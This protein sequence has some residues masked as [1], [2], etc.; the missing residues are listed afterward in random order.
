MMQASRLRCSE[1]C[2]KYIY[3]RKFLLQLAQ[4]IKNFFISNANCKIFF[5]YYN[6]II[7]IILLHIVLS[8]NIFSTARPAY[9]ADDSPKGNPPPVS[10]V[11]APSRDDAGRSQSTQG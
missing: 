8:K 1:F 10:Y 11:P 9:R 6:S 7:R 5:Y 3:F 2:L 4:K